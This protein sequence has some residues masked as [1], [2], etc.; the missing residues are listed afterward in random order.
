MCY[1]T[2]D[3]V[4]NGGNHIRILTDPKFRLDK[5]YLQN[6]LDAILLHTGYVEQQA[7]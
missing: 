1:N 3:E 5:E 4:I 2:Y 7:T 6:L